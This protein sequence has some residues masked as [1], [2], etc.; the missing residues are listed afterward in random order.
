MTKTKNQ[1]T[2]SLA[3]GC[4]VVCVMFLSLISP[5]TARAETGRTLG[6]YRFIPSPVVEDPFITTHFRSFTGLMI[7]LDV[8]FP[9]LVID[10]V[11]PDTLLA[12]NGNFVFVVADFEYQHAV[13]PR[14]ALFIE[15]QGASRVGTTGQ[16]L[17]SQG[18][19]VITGGRAGAVV[20]LWRGD[21]ILLSGSAAGGYATTFLVDFVGFAEDVLAGN[22][23][24]ASIIGG[25]EGG[26]IDG[27]LIGAWAVNEWSGI[28]AVGQ[29]GYY[30]GQFKTVD[31]RW[32]LAAS[33]SVDFGQR[34]GTP[35]GLQ[36]SF[37]VDRLVPQV[38]GNDPAFSIAGG[39]YYTGR[40]DF[41]LGLDVRW[42]KLPLEDWDFDLAPISFGIALRYYF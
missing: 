23:E 6:G 34:G 7:A 12:L 32:R 25:I 15:G 40:D 26:T 10:D 14:V 30:G 42:T 41:T 3:A 9:I 16:A 1:K 8:T 24:N 27:G 18:V 39:V 11:P 38:T 19:T 20:E 2:A 17:L 13:H 31:T 28:N 37:D 4:L 22:I 29:I 5:G 21:N 36:L 33:G 35:V